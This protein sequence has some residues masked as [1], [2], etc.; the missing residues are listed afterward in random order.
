MGNSC[1]ASPDHR[2]AA[3]QAAPNLRELLICL[4]FSLIIVRMPFP[5]RC[6]GVGRRSRSLCLCEECPDARLR[7]D[8]EGAYVR[9]EFPSLPGVQRTDQG[10]LPVAGAVAL[11]SG[12]RQTAPR[13]LRIAAGRR[14]RARG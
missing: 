3:P 7:D 10:A 12:L 13:S 14:A 11:L 4:S 9:D 6:F 2:P 5:A 1:S 8:E